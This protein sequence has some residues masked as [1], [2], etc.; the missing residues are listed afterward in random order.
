M[1]RDGI[2]IVYGTA[3]I[4]AGDNSPACADNY[5]FFSAFADAL[6]EAENLLRK[7]GL[8]GRDEATVQI[9]AV[10]ENDFGDDHGYAEVWYDD[11]T[12]SIYWEVDSETEDGVM[13]SHSEERIAIGTIETEVGK[14]TIYFN[15][16]NREMTAETEDG[17]KSEEIGYRPRTLRKAVE[18]V[19]WM[20]GSQPVWG[21]APITDLF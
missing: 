20:Y 16:S 1:K 3:L 19:E 15:G 6:D 14:M 8:P 4:E 5:E 21:Y 17:N 18:T 13:E 7:N 10:T 11:A 9:V 2:T 12:E